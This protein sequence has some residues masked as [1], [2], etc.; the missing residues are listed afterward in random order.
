MRTAATA[1]LAP[2]GLTAVRGLLDAAFAGEFADDDWSHALGGVHVL[3]TVDGEL[4]GH[5]SVVVRQLVAGGRT[6]RTGYVEAVATAAHQRRRGVASAV[7]TEAER[8]VTGGFELGAL[9]ASEEAAALY[10][11]R[12]WT[13][14]TG[15]TAALTPDGVVDTPDEGVFVQPTPSTPAPPDTAGRLVCDWRR[16][17]LW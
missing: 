14:W 3:A 13:A 6:L 7:M 2:H 15:P 1:D 5:A 8:L 4:V 17:D 12:G 16:G 9:S 10:A 11:G